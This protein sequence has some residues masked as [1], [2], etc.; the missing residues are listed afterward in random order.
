MSKIRAGLIGTVVVGAA[1]AAGIG[2]AH[3]LPA[4]LDKVKQ[5][6]CAPTSTSGIPFVNGLGCSANGRG[7]LSP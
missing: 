7:P 2:T 6:A 3:A 1:L 5:Q 4:G